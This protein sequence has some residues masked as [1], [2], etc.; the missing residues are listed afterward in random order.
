MH[1]IN[2]L[3]K[4]FDKKINNDIFVFRNFNQSLL[5]FI[6]L[7]PSPLLLLS[8]YEFGYFSR[9]SL[10]FKNQLLQ[11][12]SNMRFLFMMD[13]LDKDNSHRMQYIILD[14]LWQTKSFIMVLLSTLRYRPKLSNFENSFTLITGNQVFRYLAIL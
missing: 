2:H 11:R 4:R 12:G 10:S 5:I 14:T 7:V 9:C 13:F 3:Q 8:W 6:H 1:I